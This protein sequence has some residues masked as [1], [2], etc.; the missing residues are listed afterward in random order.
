[1]IVSGAFY[2]H[3][4]HVSIDNVGSQKFPPTGREANEFL[5]ISL[6]S[7]EGSYR[8]VKYMGR[9]NLRLYDSPRM[10]KHMGRVELRL[11][12]HGWIYI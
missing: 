2:F 11:V 6:F 10:A 8:M 12:L 5:D 4:V 1:M 9:V 3:I 7:L